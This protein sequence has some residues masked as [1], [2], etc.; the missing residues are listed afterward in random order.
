MAGSRNSMERKRQLVCLESK[1]VLMVN[2]GSVKR[3]W[4]LVPGSRQVPRLEHLEQ[5]RN[6]WFIIVL[7]TPVGGYTATYIFS[8]VQIPSH[9]IRHRLLS[10]F[11][12][13]LLPTVLKHSR[14][15]GRPTDQ[16]YQQ[17]RALKSS[18]WNKKHSDVE[19]LASGISIRHPILFPCSSTH[20]PVASLWG[21]TKWQTEQGGRLAAGHIRNALCLSQVT[22]TGNRL[23]LTIVT[24][25]Y[26]WKRKKKSSACQ[27]IP[28]SLIYSEKKKI[29]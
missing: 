29:N 4:V 1:Y 2:Q 8:L 5:S 7:W 26:F 23:S 14:L 10:H 19:A 18:L 25:V 3:C 28:L 27:L 6:R 12:F 9:Q 16:V 13:V 15:C 24:F 21:L 17:T 11:P 20:D 22:Q